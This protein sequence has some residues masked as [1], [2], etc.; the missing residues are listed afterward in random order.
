MT[1]GPTQPGEIVFANPARTAREA[2]EYECAM[3]W[4]D[5]HGVPSHAPDG[6][7]YSLVGRIRAYRDQN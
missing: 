4:L 1:D 6:G 2:E 7:N 5:E 3:L